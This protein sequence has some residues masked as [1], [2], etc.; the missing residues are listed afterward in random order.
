MQS[1]LGGFDAGLEP[2]ALPT[3]RP[4]QLKLLDTARAVAEFGLSMRMWGCGAASHDDVA[5]TADLAR[6]SP[7]TAA[8][9]DLPFP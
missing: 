4:D 2:L 3:P 8:V 5:C 6:D 7:V 1:P 9:P